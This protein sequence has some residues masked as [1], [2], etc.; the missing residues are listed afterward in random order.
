MLINMKICKGLSLL[1]N[2]DTVVPHLLLFVS[3]EKSIDKSVIEK[4]TIKQLSR[5]Y[6]EANYV[7]LRK[8]NYSKNFLERFSRRP[9]TANHIW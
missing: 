8:I 1:A 6:Y 5:R 4:H 2:K 7:L 9:V 3:E